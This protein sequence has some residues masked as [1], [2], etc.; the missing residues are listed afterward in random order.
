MVDRPWVTLIGV[1]EDGPEGLSEASRLALQEADLVFGAPRHLGLLGIAGQPFPVP[2]STA[3]ILAARGRRVVVLAS[4]DP[5]W[6]GAG[7]SLM[8]D[9]QPG[10]WVSHPAPSTFQLLANRIGWRLE[11]CLCLGLHAAPLTRLRPVLGRGRKLICLLR[12]GA[13]VAEL[14]AFL[15]AEGFGAS[16]LVIGEALGG[17]RER[18]TKITAQDI[19]S[20][21]FS[22]LV[23]V[24]VLAMGQGIPQ[25]SGLPDALFDHDGQITKRPVRALTLSALAPRHGEVLWDLGA[26]SGSI[27]IEFLLASEGSTAHAVEA[28]PARGQR[29]ASNAARFGLAHRWTLHP[30]KSLERLNILPQPDVVFVG[31]G[32]SQALIDALWDRM[33]PGARLVMNGVTLETEALLYAAHQA[34]GGSLLRIDIAEAGA[35]GSRH[36]WEAA[37]PVVQWSVTR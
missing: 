21:V 9:L 16:D 35:L 25:A 33:P 3:P 26:G 17:P 36:G 12:D 5:F 22:D 29:A 14:A 31:G 34:R 37:R 32:A 8:T 13:A 6:H 20:A 2:F 18:I 27:S 24:A 4:G 15:Q 28:D 19:G 7:G 1:G 23:A 11:T 30:G 10:D